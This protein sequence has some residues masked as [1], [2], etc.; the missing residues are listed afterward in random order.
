MAEPI[1][2]EEGEFEVTVEEAEAADLTIEEAAAHQREQAAAADAG[3]YGRAREEAVEAARELN[4]AA[5]QGR[6]GLDLEI[7]EAERDV[8]VLDEADW[9]QEIADDQAVAAGEYLEAGDVDAAA[10][11]AE[12]AADHAEVAEQYG[13]EGDQGGVH[14]YDDPSSDS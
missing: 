14:G 2:T 9:Q 13:S 1:D 7:I 10:M 12:E 5:D 6:A 11:Y 3:D 4:A 8:A